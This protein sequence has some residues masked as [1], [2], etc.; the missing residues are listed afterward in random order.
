[1]IDGI[2]HSMYHN[3]HDYLLSTEVYISMLLSKLLVGDIDMESDDFSDVISPI[4]RGKQICNKFFS[5]AHDQI[6]THKKRHA[7]FSYFVMACHLKNIWST[8]NQRT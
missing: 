4:I 1:M 7:D 6:P 8:A 5:S 2:S 3:C